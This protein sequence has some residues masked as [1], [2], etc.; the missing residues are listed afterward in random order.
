MK[1]KLTCPRLIIPDDDVQIIENN[2]AGRSFDKNSQDLQSELAEHLHD[3]KL[4]D[5]QVML[6]P[7]CTRE[8][9]ES[10][11]Q[12]IQRRIEVLGASLKGEP[13]YL[14]DGTPVLRVELT[15]LQLFSLEKDSAIYRVEKTQFFCVD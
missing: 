4:L 5:V 14:S 12:K 2:P 6:R 10:A 13:F 8:Q 15:P 3:P 11:L 9:Y 1:K 7:N